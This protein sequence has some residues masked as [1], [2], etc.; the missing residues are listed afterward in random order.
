VDQILAM[1]EAT[2]RALVDDEA[3]ARVS[4]LAGE[5]H[6]IIE[7]TVARLDVG[8]VIGRSGAHADA[9]RKLL[10]AAAAK[11]ALHITL[12]IGERA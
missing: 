9:L 10:M 12:S 2:V 11:H 1:V 6:T 4:L 7:V 3:S 8:K 5:H